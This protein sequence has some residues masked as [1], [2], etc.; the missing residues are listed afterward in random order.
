[1]IYQLTKVK[2]AENPEVNTEYVKVGQVLRGSFT[3]KPEVGDSFFFMAK[4]YS[5]SIVTSTV[6]GIDTDTE[7][8]ITY[9]TT[10]NSV[11]KLEESS[12]A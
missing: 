1:M 2:R 7:P 11:Y 3:E 6:K 12:D 4:R 8:G 5:E 9:I 10:R